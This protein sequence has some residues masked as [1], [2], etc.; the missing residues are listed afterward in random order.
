VSTSIGVLESGTGKNLIPHLV[1]DK[2]AADWDWK[3]TTLAEC[4]LKMG[5]DGKSGFSVFKRKG[6]STVPEGWSGNVWPTVLRVS[7]FDII[8]EIP[9]PKPPTIKGWISNGAKNWV[10]DDHLEIWAVEPSGGDLGKP[11]LVQWGVRTWDGKVFR[12]YGNPT[13]LLVVQHA[14]DPHHFRVT[15]KITLP[16]K[17]I[18]LTI[19]YSKGGLDKER[20]AEVASTSPIRFGD[21]STIGV[22]EGDE[23]HCEVARTQVGHDAY[24]KKVK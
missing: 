3:E 12:A 11:K 10:N 21:I 5:P 1:S 2:L 17:P 18:G 24:L 16:F 13:E 15:V 23:V 19:S 20:V 8:A 4:G 7:D 22:P 9:W 14:L 6:A